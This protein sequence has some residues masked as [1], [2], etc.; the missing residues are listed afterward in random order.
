M[1]Q[2]GATTMGQKSEKHDIFIS[3]RREGGFETARYLYDN[4]VRDGYRVTFD[5]DSL[6]SGRFDEALLGRIDE[7]T[8]FV[9]VLNKGCFD[10]T[11][12]PKFPRKND[13]MRREL[14]YAIGKGKNVIPVLLGGYA[15]PVRLPD[16]IDAVRL[17]NGPSYSME[18]IDSFYGK[19][20]RFLR[21]PAPADG[22]KAEPG[23]SATA[24]DAAICAKCHRW[25]DLTKMFSCPRCGKN[26]CQEHQDPETYLCEDCAKA[27]GVSHGGAGALTYPAL[28]GM[29][30]EALGLDGCLPANPTVLQ[31]FDILEKNGIAPAGGWGP[32]EET[33][34]TRGDLAR[35]LVESLA[36]ED[37]VAD[38]S[39]PQSWVDALTAMGF[40]LSS[41][42]NVLEAV[43]A[44]ARRSGR[45]GRMR[46][47]DSGESRWTATPA[48]EALCRLRQEIESLPES[49][50]HDM[51]L[52]MV[53]GAIAAHAEKTRNNEESVASFAA[54][55]EHTFLV[56]FRKEMVV[57]RAGWW[58]GGID[59]EA[60]THAV[61]DLV[62]REYKNKCLLE[63]LP[64]E[65][66]AG[67]ERRIMADAVDRQLQ[68]GEDDHPME[69]IRDEVASGLFRF[70]PAR[71]T[72]QS[73]FFDSDKNKAW[74]QIL[75][76]H[77]KGEMTRV[78]RVGR[79]D[80]CPCGSGKKFKK[81]CYYPGYTVKAGETVDTL[82]RIFKLDSEDL[83]RLNGLGAG[84]EVKPGQ[85]IKVTMSL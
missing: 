58:R 72:R 44:E 41:M 20:K 25:M 30:V 27:Q 84:E 37:E 55:V 59:A 81:C 16:D 80:P 61:F 52:E 66:L 70:I 1:E 49:C 47:T 45:K 4:L 64:T 11:L 31:R 67:V 54:W 8:D 71:N 83:R 79:N 74:D 56:G 46:W 43:E 68:D 35:L 65:W 48:K 7:C 10:R 85:V 50:V 23:K 53:H 18:Y 36:R 5:L 75:A 63:A 42:G 76:A 22:R 62:A 9:I 2:T 69:N 82:A 6:R 38:P 24:A 57:K 12:D 29:L 34:V 33:P 28:A 19:L 21:T 32:D 39:D 17:L 51:V 14:G 13:W 78:G 77:R 40:S 15:P 73:L 3:Y 60:T 26:Y